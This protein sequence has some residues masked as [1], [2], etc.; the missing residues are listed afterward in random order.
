MSSAIVAAKA[1][2][3]ALAEDQDTFD[4]FLV[5]Q[6]IKELSRKMQKLVLDQRVS[7]QDTQSQ[8]QKV[9]EENNR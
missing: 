1:Q 5:F 6:E 7:I 8:L 9:C 2:Y 3:L 4:Y